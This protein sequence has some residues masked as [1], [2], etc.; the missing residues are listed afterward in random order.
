MMAKVA[1]AVYEAAVEEHERQKD[2]GWECRPQCP[3]GG[4]V[5]RQ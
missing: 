2:G 4:H 1:V 3:V 5:S